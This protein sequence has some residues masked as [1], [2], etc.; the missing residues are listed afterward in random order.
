MLRRLHVLK[1][2]QDLTQPAVTDISNRV[3]LKAKSVKNRGDSTLSKTPSA[4]KSNRSTRPPNRVNGS[5]GA[6]N[7]IPASFSL[8]PLTLSM[9][10][11]LILQYLTPL[12][13]YQ[14]VR[15]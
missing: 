9:Q 6:Y 7:L 8:Y 3:V 10:Q 12:G 11:R 2:L 14:E 13:E 15:R 4:Q 5:R 1:D